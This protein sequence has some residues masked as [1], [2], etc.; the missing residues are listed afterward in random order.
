MNG[1]DTRRESEFVCLIETAT[2]ATRLALRSD[3]SEL[4][5][6]TR[7]PE[8]RI[9]LTADQGLRQILLYPGFSIQYRHMQ[10]LD[11][12]EAFARLEM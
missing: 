12:L 8:Y 3:T 9:Q 10:D 5:S 11:V 6:L 7:G 1:G 4:I 2:R